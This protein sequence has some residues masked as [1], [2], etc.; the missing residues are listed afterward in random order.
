MKHLFICL[1]ALL[2]LNVVAEAKSYKLDEG[3]IEEAFE[4]SVDV[5][6]DLSIVRAN[7]LNT[8]STAP[9]GIAI[10]EDQKWTFA[11][12]AIGVQY[13]TGVGW[14]IPIHRLILG[15]DGQEIKIVALYCVTLSGCGFLT[16]IDAIFL[17]V[18]ESRTKYNNN[19]K[20]LMFL[21][22]K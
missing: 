22:K 18:D 11:L 14:F 2:S 15:C 10:E 3:M 19:S 1:V 6:S 8:S 12:I 17:L 21:D 16:W 13:F 20:F 5:S 4:Q 9:Y 7:A